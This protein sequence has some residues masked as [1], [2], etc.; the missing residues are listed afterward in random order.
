M[1][2]SVV[3]QIGAII[4]HTAPSNVGVRNLNGN[5]W[6]IEKDGI[7]VIGKLTKNG[8]KACFEI[9]EGDREILGRKYII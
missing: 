4:F 2:A 7:S 6:L 5:I 8:S 3:R 9:Q 1:K